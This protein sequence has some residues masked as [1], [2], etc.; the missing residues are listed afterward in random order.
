MLT[1]KVT[2]TVRLSP[3]RRVPLLTAFAS[4]TPATTAG[5]RTLTAFHP[6]S[7][8]DEARRRTWA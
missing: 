4:S 5:E 1:L 6:R 8:G 7:H 3:H 2:E